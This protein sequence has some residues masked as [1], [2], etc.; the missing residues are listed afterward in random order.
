[1]SLNQDFA[2]LVIL[3]WE[4]KL[5]LTSAVGGEP[6]MFPKHMFWRVEYRIVCM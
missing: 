1:M 3:H 5:I 4:I 6:L 2:I